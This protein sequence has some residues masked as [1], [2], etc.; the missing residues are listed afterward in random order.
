MKSIPLTLACGKY[1]RTWS[2]MDGTVKPEGIDLNYVSMVPHDIFAQVLLDRAFD[3]AEMSI[4]NLTTLVGRGE[5]ELVAIPAFPSRV[6]RHSYVFV[7]TEAGIERPEDLVGR[8]VGVPE[9]SMTAAVWVRAFLQHDYG[10]TA[11]QV[12]WY[13]GGLNEQGRTGRISVKLADDI[14]V[15]VI[16]A[17]TSLGELLEAGQ[18]DALIAPSM[19]AVVKAGSPRVRR[20]FPNSQQVEVDYYRRTGLVHLMHTVVIRASI[21]ERHPWV[22]RSLYDAF[23]R[24]KQEAYRWIEATGA[25]K[26]SL[27]WLQAYLEAERAIFGPDPWPYGVQANRKSLEALASYVY[28]QGLSERLV[29]VEELF[30]GET[31]D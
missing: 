24:A 28:E 9:Y 12:R 6:Y 23:L 17:G 22:A 5:R 18:I 20:L 26:C 2:L 8:R 7:N 10:V 15:E 25:P 1:D 11:N 3:A 13:V 14:R 29:R 4:S 19:P 31:L 27:V 30:A 21:Y 16:P